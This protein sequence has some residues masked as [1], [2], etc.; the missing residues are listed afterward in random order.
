VI[1]TSPWTR[2][3]RQANALHERRP[4]DEDSRGTTT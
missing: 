4:N 2:S 1:V 3:G